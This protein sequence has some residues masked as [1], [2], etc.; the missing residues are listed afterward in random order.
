VSR[1]EIKVLTHTGRTAINYLIKR[2]GESYNTNDFKVLALFEDIILELED[3][4]K[5]ALETRKMYDNL[6]LKTKEN[7]HEHL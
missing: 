4:H 2:L 5:F 7:Y 3:T 1:D 6:K